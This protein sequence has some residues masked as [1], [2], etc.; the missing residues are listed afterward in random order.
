MVVRGRGPFHSVDTKKRKKSK[1]QHDPPS[2]TPF[3]GNIASLR[4]MASRDQ[5][6]ELLHDIA[7][8]VAPIMSFYGFKVGTLCEM[9][10]R[11]TCLLG[12]NVNGGSKICI[13]LRPASNKN[14]FLP[15]QDLI[16][17]MLHEL[18]H[19]KC[20]PH[21]KAFYKLLDEIKE[22]YYEVESRG[23]YKATGYFM[24]SR[25]LGS[26][27]TFASN[28]SVRAQR[29]KRLIKTR[30]TTK[31]SKLGTSFFGKASHLSRPTRELILEAIQRR[32]RDEKSCSSHLPISELEN[33]APSDSD[34]SS[35]LSDKDKNRTSQMKKISGDNSDG[36]R[37]P[38]VITKSLS[39]DGNE[40]RRKL[41]DQKSKRNEP[42]VI[43]ID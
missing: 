31:N 41:S 39:Q 5:A 42:E 7:N 11:N 16:G 34:L 40:P 22:K 28:N 20:G 19:N 37:C 2:P 27:S 26:T 10:P 17:T 25:K 38:V 18:A 1:T 15:L 12:L 23:S 36:K 3:I 8:K 14:W 29:I 13:R 32:S 4:K 43:I 21:N 9:Y 33:I 6:L 35:L 30:Y 24:E